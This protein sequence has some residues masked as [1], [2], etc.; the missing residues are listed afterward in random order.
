MIGTVRTPF[1]VWI[2]RLSAS[3]SFRAFSISFICTSNLSSFLLFTC[4]ASPN[5]DMDL[6]RWKGLMLGCAPPPKLMS[7][8]RETDSGPGRAGVD[9]PK[10]PE[11]AGVVQN[12]R[13]YSW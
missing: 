1:F 9:Y 6:W 5:R 7:M 3:S 10:R 11:L 2:D 4:V 13:K 8:N 12:Q